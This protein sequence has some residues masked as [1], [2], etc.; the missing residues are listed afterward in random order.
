MTGRE[1]VLYHQIHPLKLATDLSAG[2]LSYYLLWRRRLGL[3]AALLVQL[4]PAMLVSGAL[5]R[6]AD[7]EPQR[8]STF[9]RYIARS[10]TPSMQATRMAGNIVITVGAWRRRPRLLV[11]GH[12]LVLF[13]WLRGML[14]PRREA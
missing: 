13:G 9:G 10:M 6:W 14:F 3:G 12:L 7:L 1:R 4:L 5:I 2:F 11:I 8:R